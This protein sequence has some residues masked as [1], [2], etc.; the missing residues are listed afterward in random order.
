MEEMNEG[1]I[2]T[3]TRRRTHTHIRARGRLESSLVT[4]ATE[5]LSHTAPTPV[6]DMSVYLSQHN[7]R[8]HESATD[9]TCVRTHAGCHINVWTRVAKTGEL[10][11]QPAGPDPVARGKAVVQSGVVYRQVVA[12]RRLAAFMYIGIVGCARALTFY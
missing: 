1:R 5:S 12:S 6:R 11:S 10:A 2:I 9:K 7:Q 8:I 3:R 4:N